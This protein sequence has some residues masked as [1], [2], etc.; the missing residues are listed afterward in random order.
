MSKP[1]LYHKAEEKALFFF[2]KRRSGDF[3]IRLTNPELPCVSVMLVSSPCWRA[4]R[5]PPNPK[6]H[7]K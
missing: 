3:L 5:P 4:T 6:G 2:S 7:S 1:F